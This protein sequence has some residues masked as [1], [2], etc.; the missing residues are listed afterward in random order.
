VRVESSQLSLEAQRSYTERRDV[1]DGIRIEQR[2]SQPVVSIETPSAVDADD[3]FKPGDPRLLY[4][5]LV[6][7]ALLGG[8]ITLASPALLRS[9]QT[10]SVARVSAGAP[11]WSVTIDHREVYEERESLVVRANGRIQTADG[12]SIAFDAEFALARSFRIETSSTFRAGN[13]PVSDPLFLDTSGGQLLLVRDSNAD[14]EVTGIEEL[15]GA[16]TGEGFRELATFD[17]D[18]NGWIDSGDTVF[19]GLRLR[20]EDGSLEALASLGIGAISTASIA[21]DYQYKNESNELVAIVR[22]S[23]VYLN[24]N[25]TPGIVRQI[26][27][28]VRES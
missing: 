22:R 23:G 12:R 13:A 19:G 11:Q 5:W 26:D 10:Q 15:F 24:E 20:L 4:T 3:Y 28:A 6:V 9:G 1:L 21:G 16:R 8:R 18:Q 7:Q 14:G 25:G 17:D 27:V 2:P